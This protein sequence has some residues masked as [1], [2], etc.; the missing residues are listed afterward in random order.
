MRKH[1][2]V[3]M[4]VLAFACSVAAEG[5]YRIPEEFV[6]SYLAARSS[7]T[8]LRQ[9][10]VGQSSPVYLVV[11]S[12]LFRYGFLNTDEDNSLDAM[13]CRA[14]EFVLAINGS[15]EVQSECFMIDRLI[16]KRF[17]FT[18]SA[19]VLRLQDLDRQTEDKFAACY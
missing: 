6:G 2:I 18:K 16:K 4:G 8:C 14:T 3:G 11:Q 7:T 19:G 1:S 17:K 9:D 15:M 13:A 12:R 5:D 10:S